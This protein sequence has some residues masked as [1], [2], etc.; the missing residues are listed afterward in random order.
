MPGTPRGYGNIYTPHAGSMVIQVQREG[1]LQ[2]RTIVLSPRQVR[3]LRFFTS[4][5]GRIIAAVLALVIVAIGIE[6]ARV[7]A[8]TQRLATFE[9]TA[10]RLDTLERSLA[11]LQKRYDQ[12]QRMLGAA[13]ARPGD[14]LT[15]V[16]DSIRRPPRHARAALTARPAAATNVAGTDA[17]GATGAPG[18]PS[19]DSS[20]KPTSA[21][22]STAPMD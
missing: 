14:E 2:S 20:G 6:A 5:G 7:P 8:L 18:A 4:R 1:G 13:P 11:E 12:V 19:A 17:T 9:H 22:K 16:G 3:L 10:T 15:P 21:P